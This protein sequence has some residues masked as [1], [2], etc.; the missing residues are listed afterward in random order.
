MWSANTLNLSMFLNIKFLCKPLI[1]IIFPSIESALQL[2]YA[3]TIYVCLCLTIE[4]ENL[5]EKC[6]HHNPKEA[7]TFNT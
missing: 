3:I 6:M 4:C 2:F 1:L 5:N 7:F